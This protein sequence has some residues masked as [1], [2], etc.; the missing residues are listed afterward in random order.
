VKV[1]V[2]RVRGTVVALGAVGAA[3][4]VA[5]VGAIETKSEPFVNLEAREALRE[6]G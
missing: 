4:V 6:N 5:A 1:E 3:E 2:R